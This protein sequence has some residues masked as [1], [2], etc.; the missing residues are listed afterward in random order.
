MK[1]AAT[2]CKTDLGLGIG[3]LVGALTLGSALPHL[4]NALPLLGERGH[5]AMAIGSLDDVGVGCTRRPSR[6]AF[7][8]AGATV[9]QRR[10]V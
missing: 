9:A 8:S 6:R 10:S 4:L 7:R 1:L 5:A 2:W 3:L